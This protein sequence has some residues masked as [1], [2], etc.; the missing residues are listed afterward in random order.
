MNLFQ[1]LIGLVILASAVALTRHIRKSG[2]SAFSTANL[3]LM[4]IAGLLGFFAYQYV[5]SENREAI[6]TNDYDRCWSGACT[7]EL[8]RRAGE[9]LSG[10]E[11]LTDQNLLNEIDMDFSN[12]VNQID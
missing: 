5:Q 1:I 8:A 2:A 10:G 6:R 7:S 11:S 12:T 4:G 9:R 3:L